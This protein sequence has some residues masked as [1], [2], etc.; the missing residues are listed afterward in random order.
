MSEIPQTEPA[1]EIFAQRQAVRLGAALLVA[2]ALILI[3]T[4]RDNAHRSTLEVVV[5]SS[6]VGD[7]NYARLP[8]PEP[9]PPY[10]AIAALHGQ[11]LYPTDYKRHE[12]S[13]AD[14]VRV[15]VDEA[16]GLAIYQG[17]PK[18]KDDETKGPG[19]AYFLKLGPGEFLRVRLT[20]FG[21]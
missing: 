8:E 17:P 16:T 12:R 13:E 11:P 3:L 14:M 9:E 10:Q 4:C 18:A 1:H 2:L 7:T 19:P 15:A 21:D 5:Q 6:A 20:N